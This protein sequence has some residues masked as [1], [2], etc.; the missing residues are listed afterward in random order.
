[1][2]RQPHRE[3]DRTDQVLLPGAPAGDPEAYR[4]ER[5]TALLERGV[6]PD[7]VARLC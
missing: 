5:R 1:M 3:K 6:Q 7:A 2:G 4:D